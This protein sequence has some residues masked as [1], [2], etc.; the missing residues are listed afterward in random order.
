[1]ARGM[2]RGLV[3]GLGA[4]WLAVGAPGAV[5]AQNDPLAPPS[6]LGAGGVP[7]PLD[8]TAIAGENT[9]PPMGMM[10]IPVPPDTCAGLAAAVRQQGALLVPTGGG[11][12]QRYVLDATYCAE[13]EV[14]RPAWT[15]T[16]DTPRCFVGY[17]CGT[18]NNDGGK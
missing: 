4:A 8:G 1:M 13:G 6:D 3:A 7:V 5:V 2:R 10:A 18:A 11:N 17:T 14:T 16:S 15:A 9:P 12:A